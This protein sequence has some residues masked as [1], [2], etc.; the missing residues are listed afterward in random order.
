M[1]DPTTYSCRACIYIDELKATGKAPA[2]V[3]K[4]LGRAESA[5]TLSGRPNDVPISFAD[6][7]KRI[8]RWRCAPCR[9]RSQYFAANF[10]E[11]VLANKYPQHRSVQGADLDGADRV[12]VVCVYAASANHSSRPSATA[13]SQFNTATA[14]QRV[15][16]SEREYFFS[17]EGFF[18]LLIP[19]LS[20]L[21]R[22]FRLIILRPTC[23]QLARRM[24]PNAAVIQIPIRKRKN[25]CA[26]G[27]GCI[28]GRVPSPPTLP[29]PR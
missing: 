17:E 3:P 14:K 23:Q 19:G 22:F 20:I 6:G 26:D 5:V 25:Q 12:R 28:G 1:I 15:A 21:C 9:S 10:F 2:A 24:P 18:P 13:S 7:N 16:R 29:P 4:W 27:I 11:H 8:G